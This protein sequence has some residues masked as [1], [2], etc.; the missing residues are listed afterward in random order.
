LK[1]E[2]GVGR[3]KEAQEAGKKPGA[4]VERGLRRRAGAAVLSYAKKKTEGEGEGK[5]EPE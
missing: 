3:R 2:G 1:K 4:A 5:K